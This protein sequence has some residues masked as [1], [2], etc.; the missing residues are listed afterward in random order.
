M[1]FARA[2]SIERGWCFRWVYDDNG[3]P[4]TCPEPVLSSGWLKVG[5]RRHEVDAC[6]R[7]SGELRFRG[8]LSAGKPQRRGGLMA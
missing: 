6:G 3:E 2:V 1:D 7:H 8:P 5:E 4:A